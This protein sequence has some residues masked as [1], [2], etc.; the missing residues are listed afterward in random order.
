MNCQNLDHGK[1]QWCCQSQQSE[2]SVV[3][4][5][6]GIAVD[7]V[8]AVVGLVAVPEKSLQFI[9]LRIAFFCT[10]QTRKL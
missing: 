9:F 5:V 2:A 6:A 1:D 4:D 8:A 10:I 7:V 3:G